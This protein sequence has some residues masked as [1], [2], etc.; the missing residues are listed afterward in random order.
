VSYRHRRRDAGHGIAGDLI[1]FCRD[2]LERWS[3]ENPAEEV[4]GMAM[5]LE[6]YR[7]PRAL[8][9]YWPEA[10]LLVVGYS[11]HGDQ[12]RLTWFKH[13]RVD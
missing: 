2:L 10:Q 4:M 1:L 5:I 11:P 12:V 13:A 3:K 9:P 7:G 6:G 8:E